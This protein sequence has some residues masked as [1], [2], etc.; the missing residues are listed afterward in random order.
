M[1]QSMCDADLTKVRCFKCQK[2]GH[3]LA[4]CPDKSG[5]GKGD[6]KGVIKG[7]GKTK[8]KS[9]EA[10]GKGFGKKRNMNELGYAEETDGMD[11]WYQDDG[12]WWSDQT[13]LQ[14]AEVWNETRNDW[15][16]GWAADWTDGQW[17]EDWIWTGENFMQNASSQKTLKTRHHTHHTSSVDE[18]C[19][20]QIYS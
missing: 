19:P 2:F 18:T 13:W 10:K 11:E 3:I 8:R 5:K 9:R 12:A 4:Y 20:K 6:G 15:N 7:K 14:A 1:V 17:T 16:E